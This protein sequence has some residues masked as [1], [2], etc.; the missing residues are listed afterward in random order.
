MDQGSLHFQ[1]TDTYN[2]TRMTTIGK[3][4]NTPRNLP[5][6]RHSFTPRP[7]KTQSKRA[8]SF[9]PSVCVSQEVRL[10]GH[11]QRCGAGSPPTRPFWQYPPPPYNRHVPGRLGKNEHFLQDLGFQRSAAALAALRHFRRSEHFANS[12]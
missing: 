4:N 9:V 1:T 3:N 11:A 12:S 8:H 7:L 10:S 6:T 2:I 5:R